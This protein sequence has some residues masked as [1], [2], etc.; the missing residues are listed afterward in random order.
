MTVWMNVTFTYHWVGPACGIARQEREIAVALENKLSDNLKYCI[1][2]FNSF[3]EISHEQY[4]RSFRELPIN[5]RNNA[6]H[7]VLT[8]W[9]KTKK[10]WKKSVLKR[11]IKFEEI[12][13]ISTVKK[14]DN[15]YEDVSN[16]P[17]TAGY[18][19]AFHIFKQNDTFL[20]LGN[21]WDYPFFE[22][23]SY[24]RD[25]L[26]IRIVTCAYDLIPIKFPQYCGGNTVERFTNYFYSLLKGS[27][28]ILCISK[29]TRSD[30]LKLS[31]NLKCASPKTQIIRLG[32]DIERNL[33]SEPL[34]SEDI[35]KLDNSPF[36]LFVS[37]IERRKNHVT[38]YKAYHLLAEKGLLDKLPPLVFA[39]M[40]GWG[41]SDIIKDIK[42]DPLTQGKI[43]LAGRV[44]D[45]EL[46][47]L[48]SNCLFTVFP[49]SYEGYGLGVAESLLHGKF[50]LASSS[51]SLPEVGK[52]FAEY[53]EPWD[54][55]KWADRLTYWSNHPNELVA[56]E[57]AIKQEYKP[58]TWSD[59][60]DDVISV[61][62]S[63][64]D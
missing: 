60:A 40:P 35:L 42:F 21:D 2:E 15:S 19:R 18:N 4:H 17:V 50:V 7:K 30:L 63:L 24:A 58:C 56:K 1:W 23:L 14:S 6:L 44:N 47:F 16:K 59:C 43:I 57:L 5:D 61:L 22:M 49:S 13:H 31:N 46:D 8:K 3:K 32:A 11:L 28:A 26:K 37:T 36:I 25:I 45:D 29:C 62:S 9:V 38:L 39:G 54:V 52:D 48:Y 55:L 41:V 34:I 53:L 64:K 12:F 51:G 33:S 10:K 20:S 27:S